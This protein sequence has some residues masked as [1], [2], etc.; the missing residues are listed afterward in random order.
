MWGLYYA[1]LLVVEKRFLLK[2]LERTPG[3]L[4]H[5]YTLVL[6]ILGWVLF[7][8]EDLGQCAAYLAGMFGSGGRLCSGTFLYYLRSYA[9]SLLLMGFASTPLPKRLYLRLPER[10]S[11]VL[12]PLLVLA[13]LLLSTAYLVDSTY[14]PFLYFRF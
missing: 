8:V 13:S 10:V 4:R 2:R 6:V 5:G 11:R 12:T 3:W 1:V 9:P 7:S 14:N